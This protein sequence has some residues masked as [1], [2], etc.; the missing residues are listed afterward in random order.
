MKDTK[1]RHYDYKLYRQI[2][3]KEVLK[4]ILRDDGSKLEVE[5][6]AKLTSDEYELSKINKYIQVSEDEYKGL[7]ADVF[8][9]ARIDWLKQEKAGKDI[10]AVTPED[11]IQMGMSRLEKLSRIAK[12][13]DKGRIDACKAMVST[14]MNLK[15]SSG[16]I[17][18]AE[19]KTS[20]NSINSARGDTSG[21]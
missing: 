21:E 1:D 12:P 18:P 16:T 15:G 20:L 13:E 19:Q 9:Q 5:T 6:I 10:K 17:R 14:G 7:L 2:R 8:F 3:G 4:T 11:Y